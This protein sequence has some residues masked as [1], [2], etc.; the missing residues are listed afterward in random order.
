ML[1][2]TVHETL[3]WIFQ[4][5]DTTVMKGRPIDGVIRFGF[6]T[7]F[8]FWHLSNDFDANAIYIYDD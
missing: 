1:N 5:P 7:A 8:V 6:S 4:K 2:E 3:R